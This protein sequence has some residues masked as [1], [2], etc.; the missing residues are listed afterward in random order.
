MQTTQLSSKGQVIIPKMFRERYKWNQGQM[1][2]VVDTGDG[3][4]LKPFNV[5][6]NSDLDQVA[7]ILKYSGKRVTL[8]Q[9]EDAIKQGALGRKK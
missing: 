4:M 1:L 8:N 9:M 7:G 3:I 5:F 6:K 2:S